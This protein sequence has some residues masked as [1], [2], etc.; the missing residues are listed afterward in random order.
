MKRY[1][2]HTVVDT[3]HWHAIKNHPVIFG[4]KAENGWKRI[5]HRDINLPLR[6]GNQVKFSQWQTNF[7]RSVL[8]ATINFA[9]ARDVYNS[10]RLI[11][12]KVLR[13]SAFRASPR[14]HCASLPCSLP[15][16]VYRSTVFPHILL[17][18]YYILAE[19]RNIFHDR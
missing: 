5:R 1:N 9:A 3:R 12:P 19:R 14:C 17:L 16:S 7:I 6:Q 2:F 18:V 15:P 8:A 11:V 4:E 13:I 10:P